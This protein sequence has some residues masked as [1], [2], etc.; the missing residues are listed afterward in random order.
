MRTAVGR[1]DAPLAD[2]DQR[3][4]GLAAAGAQRGDVEPGGQRTTSIAA[5]IPPDALRPG[6][7]PLPALQGPHLPSQNIVDPERHRSRTAEREADLHGPERRI[8]THP[9]DPL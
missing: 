1:H 6:G 7:S 2:P 4:P 9:R 5:T 8:G 3:A